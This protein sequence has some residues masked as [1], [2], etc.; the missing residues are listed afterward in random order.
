MRFYN[1]FLG[2][3]ESNTVLNFSK[4]DSDV[5]FYKNSKKLGSEWYYS[6]NPI[7]YSMNE[8][9][10]R[11]KS[12]KDIDLENYI[13]FLGCS[14][15]EGIGVEL[16]KSFSYL[17]A[18]E[19]KCDYYNLGIGASGIDVLEHNLVTWFSKIEQKPK[20]VV[21]QYPGYVRF[22]AKHPGYKLFLKNGTWSDDKNCKKFIAS[23]VESGYFL[24]RA[25]IAANLISNIVKVPLIK[26]NFG[27]IREY[28]FGLTVRQY[29]LG[30]DLKHGGIES[31]RKLAELIL[32]HMQ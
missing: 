21:I 26:L 28:D 24:A 22:L 31:N 16:E 6:T 17:V 20:H 2:S 18:Q 15:T 9:G 19:K 23:S 12:I 3:R 14:H 27:G 30:R 4:S 8:Y 29:D 7:T 13:L 5:E 11:C 25:R 32:E 1:G 10:H